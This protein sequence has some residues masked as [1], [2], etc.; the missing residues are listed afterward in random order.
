MSWKCGRLGP[1][2]GFQIPGNNQQFCH[3]PLSNRY[4]PHI[5]AVESIPQVLPW[6]ARRYI[7]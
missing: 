4:R 6:I 7:I 3:T 5:W 1:D 2:I